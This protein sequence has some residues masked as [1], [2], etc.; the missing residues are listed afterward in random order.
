MG[1]WVQTGD[2]VL[3]NPSK[4]KHFKESSLANDKSISFQKS[5][6]LLSF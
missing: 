3:R 6:N 4:D 2:K 5:K 1:I